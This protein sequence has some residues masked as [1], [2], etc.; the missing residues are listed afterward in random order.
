MENRSAINKNQ[1]PLLHCFRMMEECD[2]LQQTHTYLPAS[3]VN[4]EGSR[5]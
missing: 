2:A 3:K 5:P 4:Q 1:E